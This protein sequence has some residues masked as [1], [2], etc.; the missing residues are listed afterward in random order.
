M[1]RRILVAVLAAVMV[2]LIAASALPALAQHDQ[3]GGSQQ[4]Q[5]S[6][7]RQSDPQAPPQPICGWDWNRDL[8]QNYG[9]ELWFYACDYG[10]GNASVSALWNP[11]W[12]YWSPS[13]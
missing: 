5:S 1:K 2:V 7:G 6:W 11:D 4:D 3:W 12:G 13:Q 9:F 10:D 8:W